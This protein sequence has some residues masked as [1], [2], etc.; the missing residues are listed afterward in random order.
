MNLRLEPLNNGLTFDILTLFLSV[1]H[2]LLELLT[3]TVRKSPHVQTSIDALRGS[4]ALIVSYDYHP[5]ATTLF[6]AH[7]KIPR[8]THTPSLGGHLSATTP[9]PEPI[10][11][12]YITQIG[13]AIRTVHALGLAVRMMDATK[14]LLT[15]KNRFVVDMILLA[16]FV[17]Q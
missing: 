11:W 9:I 6:D 10:L 12:T 2:S 5:N 13:N 1:K 16:K 17:N 4:I 7:L 3:T 14:I 8:R 15:G